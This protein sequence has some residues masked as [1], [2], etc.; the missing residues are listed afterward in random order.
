[1][2]DFHQLKKL[3]DIH[4][5]VPDSLSDLTKQETTILAGALD[6]PLKKVSEI[7]TPIDNVF[8]LAVSCQTL[9]LWNLHW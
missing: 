3:L 8:M 1:M 9:I 4:S 6:L 7:M 2:S 5:T